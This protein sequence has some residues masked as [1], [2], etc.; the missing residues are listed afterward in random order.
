GH[1]EQ[2]EAG[3]EVEVITAATPFYGE[4]GGQ[5]GDTGLIS[6]DGWRIR[7]TDTQRLP[8]D[9]FIHQGVVEE[10]TVKV[11]DAAHLEV[12]PAR[13]RRIARHHT[14]THILQAVLRRHLG[15]HVKQSG[16]LVEPE[17]MRFDFT[18][19]Q[20]IPPEEVE[21]IELD[22]NEAV[23]DNLPV[24]TDKLS[25]AEAME[26]G[27]TALFEEKYGEEVRVVA[28]PGLSQELCGGTHVERTGDLG[29]CKITSEASVAAGI[30]RIE[31][32]CGPEAVVLTQ[33]LGRE[34]DQAAA[35]MKGSRT[36]L[37]SRLDKVLKRQRDLEK[38]MEALKGRLA[39]AQ[40]G[41]LLD[42]V[43]QIEGVPV[44]ALKVEAG[45]PKALRDFAV[46]LQQRLQSGIVVLGAATGEKAM[47][48][49]LVTKDLTKKFP[50]GEIIKAIAPAVGG[51]GGGRPDMAQAG[52][53]DLS[54]IPQALEQAYG[55]VAKK[56]KG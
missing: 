16:S 35:L 42:Q 22:L 15:E 8:N 23:A 26:R 24:L 27:A 10:G 37:I 56:A 9:L 41:D 4:S 39:A 36:D 1:H 3:D 30:R 54:G 53:P 49:A 33:E 14:A 12:D 32:V 5:V 34:L 48:I 6:G 20:A 40:A 44:L 7:V 28:I 13:R 46:K 11:N 47:L 45:D 55:V 19:F 52:G 29:F 17:R 18:H 31:A 25:M 51:S 50:A 38:E 43:R 2:A 21:R